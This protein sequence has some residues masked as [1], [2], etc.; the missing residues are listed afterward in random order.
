[1]QKKKKTNK[2]KKLFFTS[3]PILKYIKIVYRECQAILF[4]VKVRIENTNR[5]EILLNPRKYYVIKDDDLCVYICESPR[6]V[7]D[8]KKMVI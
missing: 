2:K 3:Y 1:M 8:I 6:E 7:R 4:A 5:Y